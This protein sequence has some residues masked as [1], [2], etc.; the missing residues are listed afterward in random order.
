MKDFLRTLC[1]LS[2]VLVVGAYGQTTNGN[3]QGTV[4][5]P[6]GAVLAGAAVTAK[7]MDTGLSASATTSSAGV[8]ALAN[9]PPGRYAIT[10]EA[11]GMKKYTQ[12][13]VTVTTASTIGLDVKLQLGSASESVTVT[14]D[15]A[16]LQT[17]SSD[18]G[19]TVQQ[20]LVDNLPLEVSGTIRNPVQFI[21]LVPG[22]VGNVANDP[23]SNSSDDFKLNGGQEGATDILV[24]GVSI[25]LVSPNTQWNK[26][27][28]PEAVQEFKTLQSNFAPEFG[29][30]GDGIVNLSMKSGTNQFH[31]SAY[32]FLRNR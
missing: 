13:G 4:V 7:N 14:G 32:D 21:T 16:Q 6:E 18:I 10:V 19:T 26:G 1:L 28:S 22:F 30:S 9:L 29:E 2:L 31:A 5:D 12:E 11:T 25:S 15:A 23:G 20:S 17:E 3:I 8:F 27:V 24:D